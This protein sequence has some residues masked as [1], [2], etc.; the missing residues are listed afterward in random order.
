[1]HTSIFKQSGAD[2]STELYFDEAITK[3]LDDLEYIYSQRALLND[4]DRTNLSEELSRIDD[5][6]RNGL[7]GSILY[8]QCR[9]DIILKSCECKTLHFMWPH[10]AYV[11]MGVVVMW[12][13]NHNN[14]TWAGKGYHQKILNALALYHYKFPIDLHK[15]FVAAT[16]ANMQFFTKYRNG[17]E[18]PNGVCETDCKQ[19]FEML[20]CMDYLGVDVSNFIKSRGDSLIKVCSD[21]YQNS[22]Q[23][24]ALFSLKIMRHN[25]LA[26]GTLSDSQRI[27][28]SRALKYFL[29]DDEYPKKHLRAMDWMYALP[30]IF[31]SANHHSKGY[32]RRDF[33]DI[34]YMFIA[35]INNEIEC[36]KGRDYSRVNWTRINRYT[37]YNN[38]LTYI[39]CHAVEMFHNDS[40]I[41]EACKDSIKIF[42]QWSLN[43]ANVYPPAVRK[44][45]LDSCFDSLVENSSITKGQLIK[46]FANTCVTELV[47]SD[48]VDKIK[49]FSH[50][51]S[52]LLRWLDLSEVNKSRVNS[53]VEGYLESSYKDETLARLLLC[54]S[55]I[56]CQDAFIKR[57]LTC[58]WECSFDSHN[59]N[60]RKNI[61]NPMAQSLIWLKVY[62]NDKV[63]EP[64]KTLNPLITTSPSELQSDVQYVTGLCSESY[65][66]TESEYKM[67]SFGCITVDI[68]TK[69]N[70]TIV[71]IEV[72]GPDHLNVMERTN[73]R[74]RQK[75]NLIRKMI[76]KENGQFLPLSYK[77]LKDRDNLGNL[78]DQRLSQLVGESS[79]KECSSE[80]PRP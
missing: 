2:R 38:L 9:V 39:I 51:D 7:S 36:F 48:A 15:D 17:R 71:Y 22:K 10:L 1:M 70:D 78:V 13:K 67:D 44:F 63:Y 61:D 74:T 52:S 80:S 57:V 68:R 50:L 55:R 32:V 28:L 73:A 49:I 3:L 37:E 27:H 72:D 34:I 25:S 58:L 54:L 33:S 41:V 24:D 75:H 11:L 42:I 46:E 40:D 35:G 79:L 31:A 26:I 21:Y 30:S 66:D 45:N 56:Q 59:E 62:N 23:M 14:P 19:F 43:I 64:L 77:E 5:G 20:C 16:K 47:E 60:Q 18:W 76:E 4:T 53:M 8:K 65:K 29:S 6:L 12:N 69:Y